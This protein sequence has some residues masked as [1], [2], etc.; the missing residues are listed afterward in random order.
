MKEFSGYA[1]SMLLHRINRTRIRGDLRAPEMLINWWTTSRL[2]L[3]CFLV[4]ADLTILRESVCVRTTD[5]GGKRRRQRN[6]GK[7]KD[8]PSAP[9]QKNARGVSLSRIK[10]CVEGY[11]KKVFCI[12]CPKYEKDFCLSH[13]KRFRKHA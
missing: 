9:P 10:C 7:K 1:N 3:D 13:A 4:C 8:M 5:R 12:K 2:G 11:G 6:S